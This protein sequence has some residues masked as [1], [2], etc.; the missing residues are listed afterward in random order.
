[1]NRYAIYYK[2]SRTVVKAPSEHEAYQKVAVLF[3]IDPTHAHKA[4]RAFFL[5][6]DQNVNPA[7]GVATTPNTMS[8]KKTAKTKKE[9][10]G[11][12]VARIIREHKA[13]KAAEKAATKPTNPTL[14]DRVEKAA[15]PK[16]A[17]KAKAERPAANPAKK[18][19][20]LDAAAQV[21]RT[22]NKA[23]TA[24]EVVGLMKEDGLWSSEA[25]TP[26]ATIYSAMLT[27]IKKK[28]AASRFAKDGS[29]FRYQ[30]PEVA[31]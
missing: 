22:Y 29:A 16:P 7:T 15:A 3:G 23:M 21:L 10:I 31:A 5:R 13:K 8:K 26:E 2:T 17:P 9:D 11:T 27:E 18:L 1:M 6:E 20:G 12:K 24:K 4:C 19:S 28:G 30:Q 14:A 25:K